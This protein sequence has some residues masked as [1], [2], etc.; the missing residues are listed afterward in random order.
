MAT[1]MLAAIQQ[2]DKLPLTWL[3]HGSW[4]VHQ[5]TQGK[6]VMKIPRARCPRG[7]RRLA[8]TRDEHRKWRG[9]PS[10][11]VLVGRCSVMSCCLGR[12]GEMGSILAIGADRILLCDQHSG[13]LPLPLA[14]GTSHLISILWQSLGRLGW[15]LWLKEEGWFILSGTSS[16]RWTLVKSIGTWPIIST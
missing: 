5:P 3:C 10:V 15:A 4:W 14:V 7:L 16:V 13:F 1:M 12:K 6:Q 9:G 2:L 11:G 8:G